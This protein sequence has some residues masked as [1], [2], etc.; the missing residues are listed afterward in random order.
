MTVRERLLTVLAAKQ[1][2]RV[3]VWPKMNPLEGLGRKRGAYLRLADYIGREAD[4][5]L[6]WGFPTGFAYTAA[7]V[8]YDSEELDPEQGLVRLSVETPKGPLFQ[9]EKASAARIGTHPVKHWIEDAEDLDKFLSIPTEMCRPDVG[10]FFRKR[11]EVGERAL[12]LVGVWDPVCAATYFR[13]QVWPVMVLEEEKR[14]TAL[15][16]VMFERI[17]GFLEHLL[18]SGVGPAFLMSGPELA[19][20]PLLAPRYFE[21]LVAKYDKALIELVRRHGCRVMMHCHGKVSHLLEDFAGMGVCCLDPL[22]PPPMGDLDMA[23]AKRRVGRQMCLCGNIEFDRLERASE[24]EIRATVRGIIEAAGEN[25]GLIVAPSASPYN[26]VLT[27]QAERN[28]IA[29]IEATRE[30]GKY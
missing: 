7:D 28:Y 19:I 14:V 9:V 12:M 4:L 2:D 21:W 5:F 3:P 11:D 23:D 27:P 13:A 24:Q 30:Y 18:E 22:E 15:M 6:R 26:P 16:Q 20:P 25:G 17:H 29:M 10:E 8:N 1:P